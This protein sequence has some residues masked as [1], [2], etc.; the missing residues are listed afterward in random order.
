[1]KRDDLKD[2][3]RR[4]LKGERTEEISRRIREALREISPLSSPVSR[5]KRGSWM[6]HDCRVTLHR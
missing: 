5:E 4:F 2:L 3:L 6:S 1:M